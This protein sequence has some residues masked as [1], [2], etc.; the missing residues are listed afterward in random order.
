VQP[1]AS[2]LGAKAPCLVSGC[3]TSGRRLLWLRDFSG[4]RHSPIG[5]P[6]E[7][8]IPVLQIRRDERSSWFKVSSVSGERCL[9]VSS[10]LSFSIFQAGGESASHATA[11]NVLALWSIDCLLYT[12]HGRRNNPQYGLSTASTVPGSGLRTCD[13][14]MQFLTT[15]SRIQRAEVETDAA[16]ASCLQ[17]ADIHRTRICLSFALPAVQYLPYPL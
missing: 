8:S 6:T 15:Y 1:E 7:L 17:V 10:T 12:L 5:A 2:R 16:P 14:Q 4:Q 11:I 3:R 13:P 9:S